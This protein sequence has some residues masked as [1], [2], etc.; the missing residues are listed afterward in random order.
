MGLLTRGG[1]VI[2]LIAAWLVAGTRLWRT[3]VPSSLDTGGLDVHRYFTD[4]QL[5]EAHRFSLFLELDWL[6][7]TVATLVALVVL[8]R[9]APRFAGGIGL[10][11]IGSG[12]IV[13]MVTLVTLFFVGLPF[14]LAEQIWSA[15]HGLAP[16]DYVAWLVAPWAQL[17][18]E[19]GYALVAIVVVM[20]LGRWLGR[21]WWLAGAPIFVA[22]AVSFV[23]LQGY[24][25][26]SGTTQLDRSYRPMIAELE[27]R[28]HV[29]P[30]V[31]ELKVSDWTDQANAFSAGLGPSTHVVVWNTLLDGGYA[32]DEVRVVLAHELGHV[33]H[34]HLWKLLGWIALIGFP[35]ALLVA[36]V[37]RA[38]GGIGSPH[39]IPLA[40]LVV[41]VAGLVAAP[42]QNAVSR[43]YEAEA[44]WSALKATNDPRA[45]T[46][47]F[48]RFQV[49]G[50][51]EPSPPA[52]EYLWRETHPTIAQRIAMAQ[53]WASANRP[54]ASRAGS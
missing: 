24:L 7:G 49:E 19:A 25:A 16:H 45:M 54:A 34:R 40:F 28:E 35:I 4:A 29:H 39:A 48:E 20:A 44:D 23:F 18:F 14:A 50:L 11:P 15:N 1:T 31:R 5:A 22:L 30:P 46:K 21:N 12:V 41:V 32:R 27:R 42:F 33:A 6:L 53:R 17:A 38:R 26:A 2:L 47:L 51:V 9:R 43:R 52:W 3:S 10:G 36:E 8:V 37:T 13:G